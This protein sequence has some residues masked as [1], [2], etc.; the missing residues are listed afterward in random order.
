MHAV[1]RTWVSC[2]SEFTTLHS[3]LRLS[4]M[5]VRVYYK[6]MPQLHS[7]EHHVYVIQEEANLFQHAPSALC[8]QCLVCSYT[9]DLSVHIFSATV[10]GAI[11][12]SG[13]LSW[14]EDT[15]S[16]VSR[17]RPKSDILSSFPSSTRM[18]R[19]ARSRWRIPR[20]ERYSYITVKCT[21]VTYTPL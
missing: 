7:D 3:A 15:Y 1:I 10:S 14:R 16:G 6:A 2:T 21:N 11:H 13:N 19:Q 17:E 18:L 8:I 20:E 5:Y 12:L 4:C 9:S